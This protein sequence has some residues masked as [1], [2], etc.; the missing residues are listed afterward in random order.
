MKVITFNK[1]RFSK[2]LDFIC[3][4]RK[5]NFSSKVNLVKKILKDVKT[6][7]DDAIIYYQKKFDKSSVSKKNIILGKKEINKIVKNLNS[8][9][10]S[11]IRLA[12]ERVKDF[13][14][15]QSIKSYKYFGRSE[16]PAPE[17]TRLLK[18]WGESF[19]TV[20][21]GAGLQPHRAVT[22]PRARRLGSC[23]MGW[24][25]GGSGRRI[26]WIVP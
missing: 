10:K 19:F 2:D 3:G 17:T 6:K 9:V 8:S 23:F 12:F 22:R 4:N 13:H 7:G 1:K 26:Q 15:R 18:V 5:S 21:R 14:E 11:S 20:M 24:V 16:K 25:A